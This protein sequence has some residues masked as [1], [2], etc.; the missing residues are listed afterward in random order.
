MNIELPKDLPPA[1]CPKLNACEPF[2]RPANPPA[3]IPD[4]NACLGSCPP[5]NPPA[6]PAAPTNKGPAPGIKDA[7]KGKTIGAAFF[8]FLTNFFK[9]NSS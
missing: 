3:V 7:A 2:A 9:K 5:I 4:S 8:N 6:V 1:C